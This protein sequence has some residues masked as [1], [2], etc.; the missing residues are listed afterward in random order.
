MPSWQATIV[1]PYQPLSRQQSTGGH[2]RRFSASGYH[3]SAKVRAFND[4]AEPPAVVRRYRMP[5]E[6]PPRVNRERG[7]G[8][9]NHQVGIGTGLDGALA[10][11]PCEAR[12]RAHIHCASWFRE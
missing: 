6:K 9:P 5:V 7:V 12:R 4:A 1:T 2:W 8:I 3:L 11:E 10:G